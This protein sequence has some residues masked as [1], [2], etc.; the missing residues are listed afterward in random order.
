MDE[1]R[2]GAP[3]RHEAGVE[4]ALYHHILQEQ[5]ILIDPH[6]NLKQTWNH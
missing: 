3:Q 6:H 5:E 4:G 2:A 1:E